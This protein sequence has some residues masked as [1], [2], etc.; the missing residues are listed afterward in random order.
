MREH[1]D[2]AAA[3]APAAEA[4]EAAKQPFDDFAATAARTAVWPVGALSA[5]AT[6]AE[7]KKKT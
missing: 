3:T 4:P 6:S 2:E 5:F 1:K 7:I